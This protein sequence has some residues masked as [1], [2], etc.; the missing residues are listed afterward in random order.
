MHVKIHGVES[1]PDLNC[2]RGTIIAWNDQKQRYNIYVMDR[3]KVVGLKPGNVILEPG[4]VGMIMGLNAKPELNG[5]YG[6]IKEWVR[7][8]N[9]YEVQLNKDQI[10]RVKVE[11]IRV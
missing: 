5:R 7:E 11:N 2:L 4:T 9:R 10:I 6:K 3:S 1:Q 8:S